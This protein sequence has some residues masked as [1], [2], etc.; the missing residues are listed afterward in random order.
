MAA[1]KQ[2]T[3]PKD[4]FVLP[5]IVFLILV[6]SGLIL[7]GMS[8]FAPSSIP[9][10]LGPLGQFA[11]TLGEDYSIIVKAV[12]VVALALH[13]IEAIIAFRIARNLK[14]Q[15]S[16]S[17]KWFLLTF[18]MGIFSLRNLLKQKNRASRKAK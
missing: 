15:F 1:G 17:V 4:F 7:T 10:V 5:S 14:I 3:T 11:R 13:V 18:V 6:P 9:G 2:Q 8:A 12:C 16:T